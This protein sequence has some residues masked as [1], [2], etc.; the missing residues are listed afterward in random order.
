MAITRAQQ[1]KQMLRDGGRIG[2]SNGS[3]DEAGVEGGPGGGSTYDEA[4]LD[5]AGSAADR[6]SYDAPTGAVDDPFKGPGQSPDYFTTTNLTGYDEET[7]V[8]TPPTGGG[9]DENNN[10]VG[11]GGDGSLQTLY[12]EGVP[13][14]NFPGILGFASNFLRDFRNKGLRKNIDYFREL[15]ARGRLQDYPQT[16]DGYR[17]YLEDRLSGKITASGNPGSATRDNDPALSLFPQ[18]NILDPDEKDDN[19]E[20]DQT[21]DIFAGIAP[22]IAGSIFDFDKLRRQLEEQSAADGG[23]IGA[24]EGGIMKASYG[25]DDA[26]GEAFEEFLRLKKIKEIP[27]DM[28]FDEYLDQLDIDVPYSRKDRGEQRTMAQEGGM[29]DMGG[30][31]KDYREG[32]FVPIGEEERADDVPA[33]LSKNEFVF[34]ADAVRAAGGG[35]IDKGAEVMQ[36][37]MDNLEAG[38]MISEESQGMN[39]AQEM[40]NQAQMLEGRLG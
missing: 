7:N 15:Q 12:N 37:M 25:Y 1:V 33:R 23:R 21:T 24:D 31:E 27:E 20:E 35:N 26:M 38:G 6:G 13:E 9:G 34:T 10:V 36:N 16:V 3:Y 39:P 19:D 17:Q 29:I 4:G 5:V 30:L 2:L 40:F 28:E 18:K 11:G 14:S 8:N 32:G 22:R